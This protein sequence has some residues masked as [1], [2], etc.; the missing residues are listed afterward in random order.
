MQANPNCYSHRVTIFT[1]Q[2][3][4]QDLA[5][6][7]HHA[8]EFPYIL[9]GALQQIDPKQLTVQP[10]EHALGKANYFCKSHAPSRYSFNE[11]G[12]N[13]KKKHPI[14]ALERRKGNHHNKCQRNI[15]EM[16]ITSRTT[17]NRRRE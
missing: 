10:Q 15:H 1:Y 2:N 11:I 5:S 8:T 13:K 9:G 7:I 17:L 16:S 14:R 6:I 3:R 12:K 4:T